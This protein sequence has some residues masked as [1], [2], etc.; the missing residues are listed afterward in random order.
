MVIG[1]LN[2]PMNIICVV[3]DTDEC[4]SLIFIITDEFKVPN[5]P[6]LFFYSVVLVVEL[7]RHSGWLLDMAS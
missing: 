2:K 7:K 4:I 6:A 1:N 3:S 5:K